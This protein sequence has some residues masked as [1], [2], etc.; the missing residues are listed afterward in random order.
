MPSLVGFKSYARLDDPN[1]PS[2]SI[3]YDAAMQMARDAG[4]PEF[5]FTSN[6]PKLSL[7]V[8]ALA[9][10]HYDNRGGGADDAFI[11]SMFTRMRRELMYREEPS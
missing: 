3:C 7:L 9:A 6:D 10:H 4:V 11:R 8:Y 2:A 1:D 5:L